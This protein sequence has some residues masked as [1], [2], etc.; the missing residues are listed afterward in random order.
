MRDGMIA[1]YQVIY[2]DH[3]RATAQTKIY[4]HGDSRDSFL[5]MLEDAAKLLCLTRFK[6]PYLFLGLG[7]D[8]IIRVQLSHEDDIK[9][10]LENSFAVK[11]N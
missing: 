1:E 3:V 4:P 10:L 2:M 7:S 5:E 9:T 6:H 11:A 8:Y